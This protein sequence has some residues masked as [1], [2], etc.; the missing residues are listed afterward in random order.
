M[1]RLGLMA[2]AIAIVVYAA[3]CGA[4]WAAQR[5]LIYYPTIES[6]HDTA[7]ALRIPT[8]GAVLKV[9]HV[10]RPG[11]DAV[12]YFGGNSEDVGWNIEAFAEALPNADLY[13]V[14]YRGYGGSS[15]TPT[16]AALLADAEVVF[17]E[18]R[19]NHA[20]VA[21]IGRSLGSGV[22]V[23]LAS[24]R[25]V[26]KLVLVTPYDSVA[27]VAQRRLSIVP[28]SWLLQDTFDSFAKAGKVRA[29][30]LVL[31]AEHDIVIPRAHSD[32]LV[33]AFAP[34]QAQVRTIVG[35]NHD[36]IS[37]SAEYRAALA[38]FLFR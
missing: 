20:R 33:T 25:D 17:D 27:N 5:S 34:Q 31:L 16:E 26:S 2:I 35:T 22:A 37:S 6:V 19:K 13:L 36:S 29:P 10:A 4:L 23:H 12:L 9:W 32:R 38:A 7:E 28:V 24:V 30:V 15:G 3:I 1:N 18:V 8:N 11:E 14:N 21:V